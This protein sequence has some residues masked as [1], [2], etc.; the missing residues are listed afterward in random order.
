MPGKNVFDEKWP[1]NKRKM[2]SHS[3]GKLGNTFAEVT[4]TIDTYKGVYA[5]TQFRSKLDIIVKMGSRCLARNLLAWKGI[6]CESHF[7]PSI[8]LLS[9]RI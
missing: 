8:S 5:Y 1:G 9:Y 2:A 6:N 7:G 4:Y 3:R